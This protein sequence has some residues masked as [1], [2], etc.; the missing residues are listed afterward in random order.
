MTLVNF[1][2]S[3]PCVGDRSFKRP[4]Y[5]LST[6]VDLPIMV[7]KGNGESRFDSGKGAWETVTNSEEGT[8]HVNY[9]IPARGGGD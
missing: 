2:R 5:R 8:M 4:S 6:V 7:L 9:P 3:Q 1:D